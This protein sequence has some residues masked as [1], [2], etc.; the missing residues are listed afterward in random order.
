M[1]NV[2]KSVTLIA[3]LCAGF[4]F[5]C[6]SEMQSSSDD[7]E[8]E[9]ATTSEVEQDIGGDDGC[10]GHTGCYK[11]CNLAHKCSTN[12]AQC[13]PR[14]VCLSQCDVDFPGC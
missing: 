7:T 12:P 13:G 4:G 3:A 9:A 2:F 11:L 8:S 5:G 6:A 14:D 1:R 10:G